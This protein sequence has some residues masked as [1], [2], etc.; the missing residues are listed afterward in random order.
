MPKKAKE[1]NITGPF[2]PNVKTNTN[3]SIKNQKGYYN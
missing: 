3:H 1:I 2:A